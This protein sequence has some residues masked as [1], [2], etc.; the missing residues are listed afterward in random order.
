MRIL[1]KYTLGVGD[2]FGRQ[3]GAQLDACIAAAALGAPIAP[4][5]NKSH[6]EHMIVGTDPRDVRREA[7]DAVRDRGWQGGYHVDADHIRLDT[8]DGYIE[9]CDFFTID[10]AESIGQPAS[11]EATAG[12]CARH[13]ELTGSLDIPGLASPLEITPARLEAAARQYLRAVDEADAIYRRIL[14]RR[15]AG[16]FVIEV[17]MDETTAPQTPAELLIILAAL[18]EKEIPLQTIA[19]KFT[20]RFNKGV[21]YA[22]D[23]AAFEREF[24]DDIA[25]A[26]FASMRYGL[27]GNLK[28]SVHSG[29]DKFSIYRPIGRALRETGAGLH[30][31]TAGTT[32]LE[33]IIGLAESGPDGLKIAMEIYAQA[34]YRRSELCKPYANVIDIDPTR[35]PEPDVVATWGAERFVAAVR[36]NPA[37]PRF[38]PDIRQ[39]L[40]VGF[41]IAAL[42]GERY[43]EAVDRAEAQI[44]K[45]VALNL[46]DRHIRPLFI[47]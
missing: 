14:S 11:A 36:H 8:V 27:P 13:A 2:R 31:K 22:G 24:R 3:A 7:D 16:D 33:E 23:V 32:W 34:Y 29:S 41:K 37:D 28:L 5:W 4:V 47:G 19:P 26:A 25:V 42:M 35:L 43:L 12:F 38:R 45:N 1:E 21:D 39:L 20:G 30:L 46:L 15:M 10:V 9:P 40:H 18:A 44:A 6:R 17:S